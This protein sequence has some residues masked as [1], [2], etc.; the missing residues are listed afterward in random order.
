MVAVS[1][2]KVTDSE[3]FSFW[4]AHKQSCGVLSHKQLQLMMCS[5]DHTDWFPRNLA[6]R[7]LRSTLS[8]CLLALEADEIILKLGQT[9]TLLREL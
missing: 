8:G 7:G 4:E 2:K 5:L 3:V 6:N 1:F 9:S